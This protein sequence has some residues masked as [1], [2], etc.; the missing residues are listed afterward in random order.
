MEMEALL[1]WAVMESGLALVEA[2]GTAPQTKS[3]WKL[4][5]WD[6]NLKFET[7][8]TLIFLQYE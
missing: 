3:Y 2:F 1:N 5:F 4:I 7:L 6:I 8:Q